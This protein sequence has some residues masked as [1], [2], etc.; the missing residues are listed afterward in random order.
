MDV[1]TW[2]N[3]TG[4]TTQ[5]SASLDNTWFASGGIRLERDS[6]LPGNQV[7]ALP[8]LGLAAVRDYAG[9]TVK[10]R[11]AYG[12][13]IRPP[14]TFPR[15]MIPQSTFT[16]TQP[17]VGAEK[18][19]GTEAGFDVAFRQ[20]LSLR[21]TRFDQRA[22]GLIQQVALPVDSNPLSRRM[23]YELENVG[24]IS[25]R[26]WEMEASANLA[27]LTV[28][29][30]LSFVDSRVENLATGYNGDLMTGDRMLQVPSRT[31]ALNVTYTGRR[32]FAT[33]GG[34]R[35]LDWINYDELGLSR[36]YLSDNH[37]THELVGQQLRNY[38]RRYNGALRVRASASRDFRD[39][40]TFEVSGD[41]LLNYQKNEPDNL[42]IVPGR[43]IMTGVRVKF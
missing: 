6:R 16:S 12:E 14:A 38:W 42:T 3:N 29:G 33:L 17:A 20:S 19:A 4:L 24:E 9:F 21:V 43:T 8:M 37:A 34:S 28:L 36:A 23:R 30:T 26:G 7:A 1:V 31:G 32:W 10:L 41:N 15:S 27:R 35:A 2:Q 18:Q 13:G 5:A 11:A 22:S 40:F 39:M 25:N